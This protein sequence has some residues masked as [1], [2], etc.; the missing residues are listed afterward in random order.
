MDRGFFG[1]RLD[2]TLVMVVVN[3]H[4]KEAKKVAKRAEQQQ[5]GNW[6]DNN[7]PMKPPAQNKNGAPSTDTTTTTA[8]DGA[9][10]QNLLN[11]GFEEHEISEAEAEEVLGGVN[12]LCEE[13]AEFLPEPPKHGEASIGGEVVAF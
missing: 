11:D 12:V 2:R 13:M 1:G 5:E 6:F 3:M 10:A 9:A 7:T 8:E 4:L